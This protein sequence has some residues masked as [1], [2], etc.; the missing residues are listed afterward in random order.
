MVEAEVEVETEVAECQMVD[1][2]KDAEHVEEIALEPQFYEKLK[3]TYPTAEE[4]LIDFLNRCKLKN[5][6]V[7][8]CPRCSA[9]FDKE[10]TKGLEGSIPKPK[11][12]GK[13]STD[14]RPKFSFIKSYIPFIDNSLTTNYV[15]QSGQGKTLIPYAPN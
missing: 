1:I 13:W 5:S 11:K 9:V 8:L 2:T 12:R 3:T 15:N 10:V 4:E 6:E 14:H 7:M